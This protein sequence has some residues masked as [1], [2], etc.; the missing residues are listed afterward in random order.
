MCRGLTFGSL[1]ELS[2]IML[3]QGAIGRSAPPKTGDAAPLAAYG[4]LACAALAMG[5][6]LIGRKRIGGE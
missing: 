6:L 2:P 3:A 1:H 5:A 4:L